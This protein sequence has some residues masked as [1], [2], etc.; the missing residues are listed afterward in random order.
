M[1]YRTINGIPLRV[2]SPSL[3]E[4]SGADYPNSFIDTCAVSFDGIRWHID[5]LMK[6][7]HSIHRGPF[8]SRDEALELIAGRRA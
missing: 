1:T 8:R 5:V 6:Q 2:R 3:Y 7:G 4:I